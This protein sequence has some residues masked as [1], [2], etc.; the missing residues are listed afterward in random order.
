M[1]P[2]VLL[3]TPAVAWAIVA[4]A[5]GYTLQGDNAHIAIRTFDVFGSNPS[6][7]GMPST[8][9][10]EVRGVNAFHPG[11]LHFLLLAPIYAIS[12]F[13]VWGMVLGSLFV[14]LGLLAIGLRAA[15]RFDSPWV[16]NAAVTALAIVMFVLQSQLYTPW[17]P[18]PVVIGVVTL[19]VLVWGIAVGVRGLWPATVLVGSLVMQAHLVGLIFVGPIV[20]ILIGLGWWFRWV[21][22]PAV[23]EI[24]IAAFVLVACWV[25]PVWETVANWPGNPGAIFSYVIGSQGSD[26]NLEVTFSRLIDLSTLLTISTLGI[27]ALLGFQRS[28]RAFS[29]DDRG[30]R[31][32][33]RQIVSVGLLI[34]SGVGA[35]SFAV[36]ILIDSARAPYL[37]MFFGV[38][39]MQFWL[40]KPRDT[41][42]WFTVSKST[43]WVGTVL[44]AMTLLT[45]PVGSATM[46]EGAQNK[47]VVAEARE[48]VSGDQEMPLVVVQQGP[49][50]SRSTG[51]AVIADE[52]VNGRDVYYEHFGGRDD[53]DDQRRIARAP[54]QHLV[55]HMIQQHE[56]GSWP[57]TGSGRVI[58]TRDV[59]LTKSEANIRLVLSEPE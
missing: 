7:L 33:P 29:Q 50:V 22:R 12:G 16:K 1:W 10:S 56:D 14:N 13:N 38:W 18:F 25:L 52:I 4:L 26:A 57:D 19:V 2:F 23:R 43:V 34:L 53:Y 55:L 49:A 3:S 8:S 5:S 39:L 41:Q 35:V 46:S 45:A 6:L 47:R 51:M 32:I 40:L 11:P 42:W 48:I 20:V 17:N 24:L 58:E 9:D 28:L 37:S 44:I 15:W 30:Q 31:P 59:Y 27:T 54:D 21:A 36:L